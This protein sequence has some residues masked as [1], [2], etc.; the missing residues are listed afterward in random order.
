LE[1]D[2][3]EVM[4]FID[5]AKDHNIALALG[6]QFKASEG[7]RNSVL[8]VNEKGERLGRYDKVN[9][10]IGEYEEGVVPG[11]GP[12]VVDWKGVKVGAALCFDLNYKDLFA[13]YS[14]L[15]TRLIVFSSLFGGGKLLNSTAMLYGVHFVAAY[16]EWSRFVDF[17]GNDHAALGRRWESYRWG[18]IPPVTTHSINFDCER[19]HL[20]SEQSKFEEIKKKYGSNVK[21]EVDQGSAFAVI[22]SVSEKLTVQELIDEFELIPCAEYLAKSARTCKQIG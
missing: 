3:P 17:M 16:S 9:L 11:D 20:A 2:A 7:Y 19:F 5:A 4:R 12:V 14:Q 22:S 18:I 1:E 10:T 6:L 13:E 21:I 8:F 15:G